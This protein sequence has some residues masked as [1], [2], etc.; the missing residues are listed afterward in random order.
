MKFAA[1][2]CRFIVDLGDMPHGVYNVPD[3]VNSLA[4]TRRIKPEDK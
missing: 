3:G 2:S 4:V 1:A